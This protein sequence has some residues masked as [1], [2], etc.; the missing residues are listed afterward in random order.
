MAEVKII[1]LETVLWFGK[2]KGKTVEEVID[3]GESSYIQWAIGEGI[4]QLDEAAEDYLEENMYDE[5]QSGPDMG[6]DPT[7]ND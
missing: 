6:D 4:F 5:E 1:N 7:F 3:E 2:H